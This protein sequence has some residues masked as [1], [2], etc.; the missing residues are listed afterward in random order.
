M[1]PRRIRARARG[2]ARASDEPILLPTPEPRNGRTPAHTLHVSTDHARDVLAE[3]C[4]VQA[5]WCDRLGSPL[6]ARLLRRAAEDVAIGGPVWRVLRGREDAPEED[7]AALRLMGSVHRLVLQGRAPAL[8]AHY[9][10]AG[11]RPG[12][13]AWEAFRAVVEAHVDELRGLLELP[14]QTNEVGRSAPLLGGFLLVAGE[15]RLPLRLLEVGA[16]AGLNLRWDRYRYE[17]GEWSWGDP[18]S[19][20][21]F[22][23]VFESAA[24]TKSSPVEIMERSGCDLAPIDPTTEQGRLTLL[25]YVWPDQTERIERLRGALRVAE[26]VP[27][28]LEAADA[29]AWL[30][31]RLSEEHAGAATVVFHSVV[32]GYLGEEGR[33]E[34]VGILEGAGNVATEA[35]PLA[36]LSLERVGDRFEVRLR[37]WPGGE[38][39]LLAITAP[40][41]PPVRWVE[42]R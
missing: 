22:D 9:P 35:A 28:G 4:R 21:R 12:E 14:P 33:D 36:W 13:G 34:V 6:Y 38:E 16:S 32:L 37:S 2:S 19:P 30:E 10:S 25:S 41:G 23:D 24:P 40:H 31:R 3:R 5:G 42:G 29:A 8:A 27:V 15:T 7:Y 20:V 39:R 17:S 11:G 1:F 26:E 18:S